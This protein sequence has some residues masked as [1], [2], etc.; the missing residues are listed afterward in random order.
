M[1]DLPPEMDVEADVAAAAY[2]QGEAYVA[3]LFEEDARRALFGMMLSAKRLAAKRQDRADWLRTISDEVRADDA[4]DAT[5]LEWMEAMIERY[6]VTMTT[7]GSK[8]VVVP[9]VGRIQYRLYQP[10]VRIAD[11]EAFTAALNA[12]DRDALVEMRP[13]LRTNDAKAWAAEHLGTTG[14]LVEGVEVVPG[15]LKGTVTY[16]D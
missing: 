3:N 11:T 4:S 13:H 5:R 6:A 15:G 14:E 1:T 8:R 7:D 10:S 2:E 16:R 12:E 9:G